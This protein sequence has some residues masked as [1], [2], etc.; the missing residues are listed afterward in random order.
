MK[1]KRLKMQGFLSYKKPCDIDFSGFDNSLFLIC[2]ETGSG[3][4]SIFDAICYALYGEASGKLRNKDNLRS[5]FSDFTAET[6]VELDFEYAGEN[7]H[8]ERRPAQVVQKLRGEGERLQPPR[9]FLSRNDELLAEKPSDVDREINN[10]L[11][12]NREQFSKVCMLAQGDFARFLNAS[13]AEKGKILESI[14]DTS[15]IKSF[16]AL[17][18]NKKKTQE[19]E[20]ESLNDEA[21]N[22]LDKIKLSS[23]KANEERLKRAD[24]S[25]VN[26]I[27]RLIAEDSLLLNELEKGIAEIL[28]KQRL[29]FALIEKAEKKQGLLFDFQKCENEL[30]LLNQRLEQNIKSEL[31]LKKRE[32]EYEG[33]KLDLAKL[34]ELLPIKNRLSELK[35]S[36]YACQNAEKAKQT[37]LA[38]KQESLLKI[39]QSIKLLAGFDEKIKHCLQMENSLFLEAKKLENERKLLEERQRLCKDILVKLKDKN[40]QK[41][42]IELKDAEFKKIKKE[43]DEKEEA[44]ILFQAEVLAHS[45]RDNCPCPVCGS[46]SHPSPARGAASI[47]KAEL[48]SLRAKKDELQNHLNDLNAKFQASQSNYDLRKRDA[49]E[50]MQNILSANED[51]YLR[52]KGQKGYEHIALILEMIESNKESARA[53]QLEYINHKRAREEME[54][55]LSSKPALEEK[56]ELIEKDIEALSQEIN[57][58]A[59]K[60]A[61][62]TTSLEEARAQ[63]KSELQK[64]GIARLDDIDGAILRLKGLISSFEEDKNALI[65]EKQDNE[66]SIATLRERRSGLDK[67]LNEIGDIDEKFVHAEKERLDKEAKLLQGRRDEL[68][69]NISNNELALERIKEISVRL[70]KL[71]KSYSCLERLYQTAQGQ[72]KEKSRLSLETYAQQIFVD[73]MLKNANIRLKGLNNSSF[74]LSFSRESRANS[75]VGL[76]LNACFSLTGEERP[77][78]TLSGG[79]GFMA[80]LALALGLSDSIISSSGGIELRSLF[81]DEGFGTLSSSL[82]ETAL[83]SLSSLSQKDV[84]IGIISHID[85][86]KER[87]PNKIVV[88]KDKFEGSEVFI[89]NA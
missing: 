14:F 42:K 62:F 45:L 52:L 24:S 48:D 34:T 59:I 31:L 16:N 85:A 46:L 83:E 2:G 13:T 3:K 79:E 23:K 17:L 6:Y 57:E 75:Q 8:V 87:I 12:L 51:L 4:T 1:I 20:L 47:S 63:A 72:L 9:A 36:L 55:K 70:S 88:K 84:M 37:S 43:L 89:Q 80:S 73:E 74:T 11:G 64:R 19:R 68:K 35:T 5:K 58:T 7:Y 25:A 18:E 49:D 65:K 56:Q 76:D 69:L 78:G 50:S 66:S 39:K 32:T 30:R 60:T 29:N 61:Q 26:E 28:E 81:I 82:L 33:N 86:V 44:F 40:E 22:L 53:L 38:Q 15:E 67:Q 77:V 27:K 41:D 54:S 71:T 21:S 10:I